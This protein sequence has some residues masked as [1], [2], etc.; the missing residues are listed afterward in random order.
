MTAEIT[1]EAIEAAVERVGA[2]FRRSGEL[3]GALVGPMLWAS[4]ER[5]ARA[6]AALDGIF[7]DAGIQTDQARRQLGRSL[8][9]LRRGYAVDDLKPGRQPAIRLGRGDWRAG[10]SPGARGSWAGRRGRTIAP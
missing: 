3:P 5:E 1:P 8:A 7:R 4:P 6:E 10:R 2:A 9:E